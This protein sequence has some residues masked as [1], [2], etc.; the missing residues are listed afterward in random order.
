[1]FRRAMEKK[2]IEDLKDLTWQKRWKE[3]STNLEDYDPEV[4]GRKG[5]SSM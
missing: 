2:R 5:F 1:M 3:L 4:E